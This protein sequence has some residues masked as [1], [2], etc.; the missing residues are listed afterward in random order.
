MNATQEVV[1][2]SIG[3]LY[4]GAVL[5]LN[6]LAL[7]GVITLRVAAPLN[8]F[9]GAL[10]CIIPTVLIAQAHNDSG[11]LLQA[12]GLYL[13]GF[14]YLYVGIAG[15]ADLEAVGI[16]WFS[17]FVSAAAIIYA[18]VSVAKLD[19]YLFG[20]LWLSWSLLWALFFVLFALKRSGIQAF[21]G[22][23][24]VLVGQATCT[25]P[26]LALL[27]GYQPTQA[28]ALLLA[29]SVVVLLGVAAVLSRRTVDHRGVVSGRERVEVS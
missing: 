4:V 18:F 12:S 13:F 5:L 6:G 19:D 9:V 20:V 22:W 17:L 26:A 10:Q 16:G 28:S 23:T 3:L 24:T 14:T 27:V 25:I 2:A 11:V 1:V 7:L 15:L 29:I 8:L 21:T